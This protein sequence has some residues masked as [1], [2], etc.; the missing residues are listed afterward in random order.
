[1]RDYSSPDSGSPG[2]SAKLHSAG[3]TS[4]AGNITLGDGSAQQVT[5][6][7]FRLNWRKNATDA[8]NFGGIFPAP[9]AGS[10]YLM[11]P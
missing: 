10:V 2:W 5:S 3:N 1:M 7:N 11:L 8:G 4:G 9:A 6:G